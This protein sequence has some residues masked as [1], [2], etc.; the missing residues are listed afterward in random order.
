MDWRQLS[1]CRRTA[2]CGWHHKSTEILR[3]LCQL[4]CRLWLHLSPDSTAA[5]SV[6]VQLAGSGISATMS[7]LPIGAQARVQVTVG[8]TAFYCATMSASSQTFPLASFNTACW[9]NSGTH[10]TGAPTA[11][12]EIVIQV[13]S[14]AGVAGSFDFCV[15]SIAFPGSEN[16]PRPGTTMAEQGPALLTEPVRLT[17]QWRDRDVRGQWNLFVWLPRRW[18]GG[19]AWA[20]EH[21]RPGI[22]NGGGGACVSSGTCSAGYNNCSGTCSSSS[23]GGGTKLHTLPGGLLLPLQDHAQRSPS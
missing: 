19:H 6:G 20:P 8:N 1:A 18:H 22:H 17:P 5:N 23:C 21:A 16:M 13:S 12:T 15:T 2:L 11:A 14:E 3:H 7:S 10:L 4:G 9:N